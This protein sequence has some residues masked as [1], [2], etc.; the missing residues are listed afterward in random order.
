M[1]H[2]ARYHKQRD[3]NRGAWKSRFTKQRR[4]W[5]GTSVASHT[6]RPTLSGISPSTAV[7][8]GADLTMTCT[9]TGF[10]TGLTRITFNGG[11]EPTTFVSAT[12][13]TTIVK[14]STATVAGGYPVNVHNGPL[15]S[16]TPRTFTF[17]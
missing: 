16:T 2:L 11:D 13:V 12:S 4:N 17:T 6:V 5:R 9:G 7:R 10:V 15:A 14:P 3:V 8:G 1:A